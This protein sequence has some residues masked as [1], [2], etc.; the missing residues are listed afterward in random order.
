MAELVSVVIP[1]CNRVH[2]LARAIDSALAQTHGAIEVVV[3]DGG[4]TDGTSQMVGT[5]YGRDPR[6]R[7]RWQ[8][9]AGVAAARNR[10]IADSRGAYV[11]FLGSDDWWRPWKV[12]L[13]LAALRLFPGAGMV[14]TDVEAVGP[15]GAVLSPRSLRIL[16]KAY[17]RFPRTADLFPASRVLAGPGPWSADFGPV[18]AHCGDI[19]AHMLMGNLVPTSTVL[20]KREWIEELKGFDPELSAPGEDFDFHLRTC[21]LGPVAFADVPA[22]HCRISAPDRVADKDRK[23]A[24]NV[25]AAVTRALQRHGRALDLPGWWIDEVFGEAHR[26]VADAMVGAGEHAAGRRHY[27]HSLRHRPWQWRA[28]AQ[29]A[30]CCLPPDLAERMRALH[31]RVTRRPARLCGGARTQAAP[32]TTPFG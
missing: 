26:R 20:L 25:L 3:V 21:F 22:A 7:Y 6:V 1:T 14:W 23:L 16:Y 2:T 11:A 12:E 9:N 32:N 27:L 24:V 5:R 18:M 4:S 30:L 31:R 8:E 15:G 13:Q 28:Y 10:G 29:V 19:R 17:R